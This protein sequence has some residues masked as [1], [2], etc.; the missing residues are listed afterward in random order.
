MSSKIKNIIIAVVIVGIIIIAY[1]VFF[2]KAPEQANLVSSTGNPVLP[3]TIADQTSVMSKD[4]LAL[5][6]SVK[7]IQ[8]NDAIFAEPAFTTLRDSTI[9]LIQDGNEGRPNPFAPLGS[10]FGASSSINVLNLNT[11]AVLNVVPPVTTPTPNPFPTGA[12]TVGP[13]N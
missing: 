3:D 4:F 7:N 9:E 8:L 1:F 12:G 10:D 2:K 6:L 13:L 5:L 11:P